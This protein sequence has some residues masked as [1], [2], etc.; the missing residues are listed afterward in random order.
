MKK[1]IYYS[2]AIIFTVTSFPACKKSGPAPITP[3]LAAVYTAA[4]SSI[5]KDKAISG[6]SVLIDN[7][8]EL[9]Q[10]VWCGVLQPD[11][12]YH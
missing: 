8:F 2:L 6:G 7:G 11:Q 4:V 1:F 5:E 3:Q 10:G 12:L 9:L